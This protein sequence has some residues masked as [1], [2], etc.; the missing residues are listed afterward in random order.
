MKKKIVAWFLLFA[1]MIALVPA[2]SVQAATYKKGSKGTNVQY[3]Q[4]N[5]SFL[6]F[7]TQGADGKFGNNTKQAVLEVQKKLGIS[8]TGLVDDALYQRI[9]NTVADIQKYLKYKGYYNSSV[10]GIAGAG[11]QK[12]LADFQQEVALKPTGI[13]DKDTYLVL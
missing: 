1:M 4:Q 8:Q 10:D 13:V 9:K 3:L 2:G 11:T 6:G 5:L 12:A 7:S